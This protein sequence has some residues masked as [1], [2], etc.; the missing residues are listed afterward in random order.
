M[1]P[2]RNRKHSRVFPIVRQAFRTQGALFSVGIQRLRK[3]KNTSI[4]ISS[5]YSFPSHIQKLKWLK[6][7]YVKLN[8]GADLALL[9]LDRP[10]PWPF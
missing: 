4:G 3:K 7:K 6:K 2:L 10:I 5:S 8:T 9:R 1:F